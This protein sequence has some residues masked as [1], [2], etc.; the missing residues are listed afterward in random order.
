M[1]GGEVGDG[2]EG[3]QDICRALTKAWSLLEPEGPLLYTGLGEH[4]EALGTPADA[5]CWPWNAGIYPG[6]SSG[7]VVQAQPAV[8]PQRA[9]Y[10]L[11]IL[12]RPTAER[13]RQGCPGDHGH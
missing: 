11:L 5:C 2:L 13:V 10:S 1:G 8:T 4:P 3:G 9:T 12:Y 6:G 7:N